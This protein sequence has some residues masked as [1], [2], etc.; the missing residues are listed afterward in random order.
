MS[1]ELSLPAYSISDFLPRFKFEKKKD[2]V[3]IYFI[4]SIIQQDTTALS[5]VGARPPRGQRRGWR[6]GVCPLA[7]QGEED[8]GSGVGGLCSPSQIS[9]SASGPFSRPVC[10]SEPPG[11]GTPDSDSSGQSY[12]RV[13]GKETLRGAGHVGNHPLSSLG[14]R[15]LRKDTQVQTAAV[16]A[17]GFLLPPLL[18]LFGGWPYFLCSP[19][20]SPHPNPHSV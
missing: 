17:P 5:R 8:K 19:R 15:L 9:H 13:S 3:I 1:K 7:I 2:V 20:S 12:Q 6:W 18:S 16:T 11:L 10:V 14:E 4:C